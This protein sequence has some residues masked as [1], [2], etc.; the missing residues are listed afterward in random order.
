MIIVFSK[1]EKKFMSQQ[2]CKGPHIWQ[3]RGRGRTHGG[4]G[5]KICHMFADFF[6]LKQK[7]Y[8][9]FL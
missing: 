1:T 6:V 9:S 5:L 3:L 7:P 4:R 8:Y 2:T